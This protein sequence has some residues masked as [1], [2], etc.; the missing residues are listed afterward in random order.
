MAYLMFEG[1]LWEILQPGRTV[2][3][4]TFAGHSWHVIVNDEM[5][6]SWVIASE[7][8]RQKFIL[9]ASDL[10]VEIYG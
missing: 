10:P 6:A 5:V 7:K 4:N 8:P 2:K 9:T 1:Q 3:V